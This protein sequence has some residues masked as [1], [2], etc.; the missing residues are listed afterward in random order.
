MDIA[1][2]MGNW[3]HQI[4]VRF[5]LGDINSKSYCNNGII[6][7]SK[8]LCA[9]YLYYTDRDCVYI[10]VRYKYHTTYYPILYM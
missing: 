2:W 10:D 8:T 4:N 1:Y 6:V 9:L 3:E 5:Q 7:V